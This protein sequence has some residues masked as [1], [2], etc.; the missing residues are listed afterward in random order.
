LTGILSI[1]DHS[2]RLYAWDAPVP[3]HQ[4][5]TKLPQGIFREFGLVLEADGDDLIGRADVVPTMLVPGSDV[6][7]LS[8][9]AIWADTIIGLLAM[10]AIAPRVPTTLELDVHVF[11]PVRQCKSVNMRAR[12]TRSGKSVLVF[13]VD[14]SDGTGRPLGFGTSM[15][16][17]LPDPNISIPPGNWALKRFARSSGELRQPLAERVR[18]E[19]QAPGVASL[20]WS[21]DTQNTARAIN[22]GI[23]AIAIE[24][25]ALSLASPLAAP[26]VSPPDTPPTA[27]VQTLSS[28]VIRYLRSVRTGPAIARATA[29]DG[30]GQVEVIDA[31][32]DALCV[33]AT[34]RLFEI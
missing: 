26:P 21:P 13:T 29:T 2:Q 32:N 17:A 30:L 16:M 1:T 5:N 4:E 33:A 22:G 9:L 3:N 24:E 19:R 6:L 20:P 23:L 12:L 31:S 15:F 27:A 28:L 11:A 10:Q 34:I 7:R 25:A 8:V 18:C 14:F